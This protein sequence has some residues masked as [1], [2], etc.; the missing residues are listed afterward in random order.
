MTE[1]LRSRGDL[2]NLSDDDVN[3]IEVV[4]VS[5]PRSEA[6]ADRH[7]GRGGASARAR[8]ERDLHSTW[9][10]SRPVN[11]IQRVEGK[12]V[13]NSDVTAAVDANNEV[14]SVSGQFFPGAAR[15]KQGRGR[16]AQARPTLQN[17][18]PEEEAIA[19]AAFDLTNFPYEASDFVRVEGPA[20]QRPLS[21]L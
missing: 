3:T 10:I 9:R 4:S 5:R 20:R 13:F 7:V 14:I 19:R 2:W 16:D 6:E 12:E 15:L 11:L 17:V 21:L 1:F 8:A 18:T